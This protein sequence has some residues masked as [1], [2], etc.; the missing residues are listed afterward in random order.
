MKQYSIV[1]SMENMRLSYQKILNY[2]FKFTIPSNT[3]NSDFSL[4]CFQFFFL[5][6]FLAKGIKSSIS[7]LK[8][9]IIL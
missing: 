6:C 1:I 8:C 4:F 3:H 7:L 9:N 5:I 2:Y